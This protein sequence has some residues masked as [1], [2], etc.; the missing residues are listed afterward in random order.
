MAPPVEVVTGRRRRPDVV[1]AGEPFTTYT[2]SNNNRK[3]YLWPVLSEGGVG[4]TRD[5]PMGGRSPRKTTHQ[6]SF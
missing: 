5:W 2:Y 4:V 3:P 6:K 1:I